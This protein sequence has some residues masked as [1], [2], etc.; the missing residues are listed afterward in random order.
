MIETIATA[1]L[2]VHEVM[3]IK[4]NSLYPDELTGKEQRLCI[5]TGVHG[6]DLAGQY[7]CYE[8]I[9]RIKKQLKYLKGIVDVYP[10]INPLGLDA[11]TREWPLFNMD[12]NMAFPGSFEGTMTE[13]TAAKIMEDIKGANVCIDIH[14][15]NIFLKELPQVRI[16]DDVAVD[17]MPY[18][19]QMN[20]DFIWIHPSTTVKEGSIVHA[21]NQMGTKAMVIEGSAAMRIDRSYCCQVVEGLFS[22]MKYMKIWDG[23]VTKPKEAMISDDGKIVF[24]NG[25]TSGIFVAMA[26]HSDVIKEGEKIGEIIAPLTGSVEEEIFSPCDGLLFTLREYPVVSEGALLARILGGS[27]D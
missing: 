1:D 6:D 4:K 24:I 12:M 13:Y 14:S 8:I 5:I 19:K 11:G 21:L 2:P 27:Y 7:I 10:A 9:R 15:S 23:E 22:L 17:L 20:M 3:K 25:E 18:A 26:K 16:N